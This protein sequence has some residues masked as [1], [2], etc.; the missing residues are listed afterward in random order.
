MGQ[1]RA[2]DVHCSLGR[3]G[4]SAGEVQ[5]RPILGISR[6]DLESVARLSELRAKVESAGALSWLSLVANEQ[7]VLELW[8]RGEQRRYFAFKKQ[9]RGHQDFGVANGQ[10]R[11]NGFRAKGRKQRAEDAA[12]LQ[13]A[14]GCNI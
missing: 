11:A 5:E 9:R 1:D 2:V 4:C 10:T 13:R 3:P 6:L 12:I 7:H 8:Q 14:Q